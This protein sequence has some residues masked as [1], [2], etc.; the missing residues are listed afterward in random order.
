MFAP[1][2]ALAQVPPFGTAPGFQQELNIGINAPL[3]GP[4]QAAGEQL[5]IGVQA[6][7]DYANQFMPSPS[8]AFALK[9]YDDMGQYAQSVNNLQF[10]ASDVTVLAMIGGFDGDAIEQA[11]PSYANAQMPL[12]VPACTAD[13]VTSQGYRIVRRLPTDDTT[14]GVLFARFIAAHGKPKMA[15]AV[16]QQ[17]VYGGDVMNG[18]TNQAHASKFAA[19]GY[20]FPSE[21]PAFDLAAQR[22]VDRSPDYVYLC[23]QSARLGPLIPALQSAGFKGRFGACEGFYNEDTAKAYAAAFEHGYV[24]TSFPPLSRVP[25]ATGELTFFRNR[26]NITIIS[27]F[28]YAAAQIIIG[29]IRR[30]GASNRLS[31]M[32]ALQQFTTY[33]TLVGSFEFMPSGDPV[34][35]N[36]YFYTISNGDWQ[37]VEASH[38]SAFVL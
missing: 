11:L 15:I 1:R 14:E 31:T 10:A 32:S 13:V 21:D 17:G 20:V 8:S 19:D 12:L 3:S 24:S 25:D 5:V 38:P 29:A 16:S 26:A 6:A 37:Y 18:F 23:G 27:A 22:I 33:N 9:T 7:V 35:P 30:T 28:A 4:G 36:L 2:L 34:D